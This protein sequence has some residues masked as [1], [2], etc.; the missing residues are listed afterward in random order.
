MFSVGNQMEYHSKLK[1]LYI[2]FLHSIKL[3][4]YK[5]RIKF[6]KDLLAVE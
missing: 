5:M 2:A 6:D 4:R 1:P 3:S